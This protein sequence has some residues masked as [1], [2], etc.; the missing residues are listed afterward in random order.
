MNAAETGGPGLI[1]CSFPDAVS[2]RAVA[3]RMLDEEHIAC[4]NILGS[5]HSLFQWNGERGEAEETG[6]LFKTDAA[7]FDRAIDRLAELH[8][9]DTSAIL[10]W[11]CEAASP[12][13]AAR[14][15]E[16]AR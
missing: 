3:A 13:T 14:P 12:A 15:A 5:M 4:A 8:S 1:W 2:A 6:V 11:R 9:Y 7:L 16:L 10:A